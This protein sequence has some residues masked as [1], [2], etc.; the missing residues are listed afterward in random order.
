MFSKYNFFKIKR[1]LTH[2]LTDTL[3]ELG[4]AGTC[5]DSSLLYA[6]GERPIE[7]FREDLNGEGYH[8]E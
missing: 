8:R 6:V 4:R 2:T 7:E 1:S 5:E 3:K